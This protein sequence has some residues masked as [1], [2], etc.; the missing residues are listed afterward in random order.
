MKPDAVYARPRYRNE[1][2]F[3]S[4]EF[5]LASHPKSPA[6]KLPP[7]LLIFVLGIACGLAVAWLLIRSQ[8]EPAAPIASA[9]TPDFTPYGPRKRLNIPLQGAGPTSGV[10]A[11]R[12]PAAATGVAQEQSPAPAAPNETTVVGAPEKVSSPQASSVA[13]ASRNLAGSAPINPSTILTRFTNHVKIRGKL[14]YGASEPRTVEFELHLV[15]GRK[16]GGSVEGSVRFLDGPTPIASGRVNGSWTDD[17]ITLSEI[18]PRNVYPQVR[19]V[20]FL[21]LPENSDTNEIIGSWT[22]GALSGT[23]D[24]NSV[25]P[26]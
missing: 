4:A 1:R 2:V 16:R 18:I 5:L 8:R 12:T 11:A 26:L 20:F 17:R 14:L 15:P 23:L 21:E 7:R 10:D 9:Q 25:L 22:Y 13:S 6:R 19:W 24:L 3:R